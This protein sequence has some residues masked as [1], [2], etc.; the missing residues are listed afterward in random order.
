MGIPRPGRSR[1]ED[2]MSVARSNPTQYGGASPYYRYRL[3]K[4]EGKLTAITY[5]GALSMVLKNCWNIRGTILA[6]ESEDVWF[7]VRSG[8]LELPAESKPGLVSGSECH[9][10][11]SRSHGWLL[12]ERI[13]V[14][15]SEDHLL[16]T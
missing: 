3:G 7:E 10:F 6:P 11:E 1:P 2:W 16:K 14:P 13:P 12:G 9:G 15:G 5:A 4:L 8:L